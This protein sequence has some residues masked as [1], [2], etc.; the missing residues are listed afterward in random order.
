MCPKLFGLWQISILTHLRRPHIPSSPYHHLSLL[1]NGISPNGFWGFV[2]FISL[3]NSSLQFHIVRNF[4][5]LLC[6]RFSYL[7]INSYYVDK[8]ETVAQR[9]RVRDVRMRSWVSKNVWRSEEGG[10]AGWHC[11]GK[12]N[13]YMKLINWETH[14][15]HW[16]V[17]AD[18]HRFPLN[19]SQYTCTPP[20]EAVWHS[21]EPTTDSRWL[22]HRV[23]YSE[24]HYRYP[25]QEKGEIKHLKF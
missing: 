7:K 14:R 21:A 25:E 23:D 2:N 9:E 11:G 22:F 16:V 19:Y 13:R 12:W 6:V 5:S 3:Y 1:N 20:C 8:S 17:R 18:S 4:H 24:A 15:G 10:R